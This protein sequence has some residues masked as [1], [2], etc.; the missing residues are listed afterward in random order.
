MTTDRPFPYA[1]LPLTYD[2]CR[3]RFRRSAD[4]AGLTVDRHPLAARGPAGQE[5]SIDV[6]RVGPTDADA[7]LLVLSGVHGVEGFIASALQCD[8]IDRVD[9]SMLPPE[10]AV[11]LVH[12]VNPWGMAWDRRQNESNVDLNRNWRR[13]DTDPVHNDAYDE[14]HHLA[15]PATAELPDVDQLLASAAELVAERGLP[16]VRDAI[17]VGQ[18]RHA[19][20]LHYG[21]ERTEQSNL[22][23][24]SIAERHVVGRD[25]ALVLDL[26]TGHGPR[27]EITL[28]SD[29]APGSAQHEFFRRHFPDVRVEATVA[30]PDATTGAK[31]G[32]IANGIRA[33][34]P[35]GRAFS[36]SAEVGTASDLEQLA[37]TY[38]SHWVYLHGD[39]R[40]PSHAAALRA[41]RDCF[42]PDDAAWEAVAFE[43]GRALLDQAIGATATW[44]GLTA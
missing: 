44:A 28:L 8:L 2:E 13:S 11:V 33:L 16:W 7:L 22:I 38:Q 27:G 30:N 19:D 15:C 9:A 14:I 10:V 21:G 26:H 35:D 3:A 4:L 36:T 34:L 32:Q 42:T 39:R 37:A 5:L 20:G 43:R 29:Q 12:I 1:R 40:D 23:V 31:S 25:R 41:Y 6:V 18:Y 24:E 17:T